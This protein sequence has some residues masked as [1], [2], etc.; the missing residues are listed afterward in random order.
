MTLVVEKRRETHFSSH[1]VQVKRIHDYVEREY[2]G[3]SKSVEDT[4]AAVQPEQEDTRFAE[5][6]GLTCR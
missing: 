1:K 5:I 2:A 3:A 4:E 6:A